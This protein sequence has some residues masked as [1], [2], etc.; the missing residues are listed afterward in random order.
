[1]KYSKSESA[2]KALF[3]KY[4]NRAAP[5]NLEVLQQL[6]EKEEKCQICLDTIV[7]PLTF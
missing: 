5:E 3:M 1:M 6:L 2:R 4:Q 7:I